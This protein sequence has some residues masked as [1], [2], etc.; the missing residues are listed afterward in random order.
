MSAYWQPAFDP[1]TPVSHNF[2]HEL[3]DHGW[4]NNEKQNY[5]DAEAKDL[6]DKLST[7]SKSL[8]A[9]NDT[10]LCPGS[11]ALEAVNAALR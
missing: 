7:P 10:E 3:G 6:H 1:S 8:S 9:M 5:V 11:H 2:R 4:G